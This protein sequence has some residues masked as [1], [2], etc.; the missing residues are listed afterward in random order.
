MNLTI[1]LDHNVSR[2]WQVIGLNLVTILVDNLDD[3]VLSLILRLDNYA[4]RK[5]GLLVTL[6]AVGNTLD[7]ALVDNLTIGLGNDNGVIWVPLTDKVTLLNLNAILHIECSTVRQCVSVERNIG[8]W[9]DNTELRLTRYND[10]DRLIRAILTLNRTQVI[11]LEA[12]IVLRNNICLN[13][14]AT[15]D[16]TDVERTE[17]KLCTWLT[18]R[19]CG[20]DTDN[21]TLL[22]HTCCSKVTTVTLSTNATTS[23]TSEHR[24]NLDR[25]QWRL[26]DLLGNLLGDLLACA[27]EDLARGW[28]NNIVESRTAEDT[29]TEA[30]NNIFVALDS[31]SGQ[32]T[33]RA[34]VLLVDDNILSNVDKTTSKVTCIGSLKSGICQTLTSTV[35][36]DKV[37]QHRKTLFE[38]RQDRVLDNLLTTLN[39]RLLWL[40]HKAS[41]TRELTNLL[42]R[43]SCSRVKHHIYWVEAIQILLKG[44]D[45]LSTQAVVNTCPNIDNLVITVVIGDK[46]HTIVFDNTISGLVTL[47]DKSLLILWDNYCIEVKRQTALECHTVTEVLDVVKEHSNLVG[48][49]L[50]H[51][52]CDDITKRTLSQH[53]VDIAYLRWDILVEQDTTNRSLLEYIYLIAILVDVAHS[54]QNLCVKFCALLVVGDDSLLWAVELKA[55]TLSTFTLLGDVIQTQDHILRRHGDR[56][57]IGR[58][59]D[60][61]RT[62][63][64]NLSLEDCGVAQRQVHRHLVTI[65]VGVKRCT[66]QWV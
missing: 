13:G 41:H 25:L 16:T 62:K 10:V 37:L 19:L 51:H 59:K 50:L 46:T 60:V 45:Y 17:S 7:N 29:L 2:Y 52:Y 42:A 28:V 15:S 24:A 36:R 55:C 49:S 35:R 66:R 9:I 3:W 65:E 32:T 6:L 40:S 47:L 14:Q 21:L 63:H 44:R 26:F 23:L 58:V 8:V 54:A 20:D 43:T 64:K 5:A 1:V 30:L 48:T 56:C 61:V 27:T 18:D 12:T 53:I 38:V 11:D 22:D 33:Q 31:R 57:T 39:T 34:T 4:L